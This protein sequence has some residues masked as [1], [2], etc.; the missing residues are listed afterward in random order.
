MSP[1]KDARYRRAEELVTEGRFAAAGAVLEQNLADSPRAAQSLYLLGVVRLLQRRLDESRLL[2]DRAFAIKR[3]V[4]DLPEEV[5]DLDD[6][7]RRAAAAA[8]DWAW[9]RYEVERRAFAAVGLTFEAVVQAK[10]AHP[11]VSFI[12]VGANDGASAHDPIHRFVV[13]HRWAGIC[14][15][16]TPEAFAA[17]SATYAGND[18]VKLA[19]VAIDDTD[20]TRRMYLPAAGDTKLASLEPSRNIMAKSSASELRT[21]EVATV[22][23]PTLIAQH[24]TRKVDVLQIDTEGHDY[25]V[26]RAFDLRRFR[27]KVVNLEMFCLP[28]D[29]RLACM[30]LLRR[31]GYAYRYDGKDLIAVDRD[32][33][34]TELCIYD[35][36][37]GTLL[38]P[39]PAGPRTSWLDRARRQLRPAPRARTAAAQDRGLRVG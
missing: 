1:S 29:E 10:L 15:E 37:G 24:G 18:R 22:T 3:W 35:R 9:P 2:I 8:P 28:V 14:V 26:L 12:Q 11:K 6:A 34:G 33:F 25:I 16:P 32:V 4:K 31:H 13:R 19:N 38:P 20:G 5:A 30:A 27:P 39:A 23:F 21:I 7:A 17:L 36:T